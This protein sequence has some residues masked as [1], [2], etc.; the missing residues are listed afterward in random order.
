MFWPQTF[1]EWIVVAAIVY[2]LIQAYR[3]FKKDHEEEDIFEPIWHVN[4]RAQEEIKNSPNLLQ[5]IIRSWIQG[6]DRKKR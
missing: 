1:F 3:V 5:K 2:F 4:K 6:K